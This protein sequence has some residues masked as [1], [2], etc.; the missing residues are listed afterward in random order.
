MFFQRD[1]FAVIF[2]LCELERDFSLVPLTLPERISP[3]SYYLNKIID[4][5]F[6]DAIVKVT[7]ELRITSYNVCYTKLLRSTG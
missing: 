2:L 7:E 5:S 4:M 1:T 3:M 6:D